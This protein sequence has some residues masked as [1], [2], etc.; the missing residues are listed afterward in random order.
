MLGRQYVN[1]CVQNVY[2]QKKVKN[3]K[4]SDRV[5]NEEVCKKLNV[6][7]SLLNY[8]KKIILC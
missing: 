1:Q 2:F 5:S 6:G 3:T 4:F 7:K 8:I